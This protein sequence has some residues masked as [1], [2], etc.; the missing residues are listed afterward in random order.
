MVPRFTEKTRITG[1]TAERPKNNGETMIG[2]LAKT[3]ND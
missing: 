2:A 1:K 3:F